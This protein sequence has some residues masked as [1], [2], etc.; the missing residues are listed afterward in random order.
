MRVHKYKND[1]PYIYISVC[2]TPLWLRYETAALKWKDT[3]CKLCLKKR[4]VAKRTG[5]KGL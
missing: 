1:E 3:T 5:R 2:G 4:R